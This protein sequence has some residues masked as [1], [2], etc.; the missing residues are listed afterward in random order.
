MEKKAEAYQKYT[1]AAM[2]EMM[3][4]VLPDIAEQLKEKM[5]SMPL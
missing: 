3:I 5:V 1:G 4:N 2:A